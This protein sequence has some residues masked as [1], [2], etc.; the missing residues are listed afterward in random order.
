MLSRP[1]RTLELA[2]ALYA[3]P[4]AWRCSLCGRIF[5]SQDPALSN[6][7]LEEVRRSF[8]VHSCWPL[9]DTYS[10]EFLAHTESRWKRL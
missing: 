6:D 10:I 1:I 3:R 5:A 7:A 2:F 4:Y 8:H 9:V